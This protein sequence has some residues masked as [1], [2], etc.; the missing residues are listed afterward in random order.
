MPI[1]LKIIE[2]GNGGDLVNVG[3]DLAVTSTIGGMIY[4]CLFGGNLKE[5]TDQN[6]IKI[7][8][9]DWWGNSFMKNEPSQ[10][11]N[12]LTERTLNE[13]VLT[14]GGANIIVNAVKQDLKALS[15][16]ITFDVKV[17]LPAINAVQIEITVTK[18][19][20]SQEGVLIINLRKTLTGDFSILDFSGLDFLI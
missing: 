13:I 12:S 20:T 1:D 14:S 11:M 18:I 5:S 19:E 8:S 6:N 2:T 10:Q 7:Q 16:Y 15:K 9:F 4:L 17:K 3:N